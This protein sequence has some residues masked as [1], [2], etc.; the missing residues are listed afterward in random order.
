[1]YWYQ[2]PERDKI[3]TL[4]DT[5][6]SSCIEMVHFGPQAYNGWV[7]AVLMR[8]NDLISEGVLPTSVGPLYGQKA[9]TYYDRHAKMYHTNPPLKIKGLDLVEEL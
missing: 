2:C 1:M 4:L 3:P 5:F 7:N 8:L 6:N 9:L